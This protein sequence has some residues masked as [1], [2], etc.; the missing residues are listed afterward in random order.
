MT[1]ITIIM[2]TISALSAA[3][4]QLLFKVGARNATN[5]PDFVNPSII[6]GLFLYGAA[7]AIWIYTLSFAKLV[8]VYAF[9]ALTFV[10][11]YAGGV[12]ILGE[13]IS[14]IGLMGILFVMTGLYLITNYS[15]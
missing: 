9:T 10:L 14:M 4:G 5:W 7:T 1:K 11:V 6:A 8:N 3:V 15:A 2:L 13:K 12:L